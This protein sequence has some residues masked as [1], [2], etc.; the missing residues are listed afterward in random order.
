[1][2]CVFAVLYSCIHVYSVLAI[3]TLHFLQVLEPDKQYQPSYI[4]IHSAD[5]FTDAVSNPSMIRTYIIGTALSYQ[6]AFSGFATSLVA[7][8]QLV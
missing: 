6:S 5:Y 1:M 2:Y 8:F 3:F 7:P 4:S